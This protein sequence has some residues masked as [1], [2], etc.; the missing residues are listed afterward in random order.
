MCYMS[1]VFKVNPV[2]FNRGSAEPQ[3]SVSICQG[4]RNWPTKNNLAS[5]VTPDKVVENQHRTKLHFCVSIF[6]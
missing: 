2:I 3:G 6:A 5:E 4:F 1:S